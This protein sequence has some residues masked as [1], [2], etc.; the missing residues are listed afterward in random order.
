LYIITHPEFYEG[1]KARYDAVLRAFPK[2][3]PDETFKRVFGRLVYNP[4][5]AKQREY[6]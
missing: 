6:L 1:V 4:V 5:F 3:R 2:T